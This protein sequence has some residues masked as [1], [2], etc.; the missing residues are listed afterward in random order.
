LVNAFRIIQSPTTHPVEVRATIVDDRGVS[1]E[2]DWSEEGMEAEWEWYF[3][4]FIENP[5][6]DRVRASRAEASIKA[7]GQRLFS[8]LFPPEVLRDRPEVQEQLADGA[9]IVVVGTARFQ[10]LHWE[11]LWNPTES[12]PLCLRSPIV[13]GGTPP[14]VAPIHVARQSVACERLNVLLVSSRPRAPHVVPLSRRLV[15]WPIMSALDP[16]TDPVRLETL[17]SPTLEA[18]MSRLHERER[19]GQVHVLH[20][21]MHGVM[22]ASGRSHPY[23]LFETSTGHEHA[24]YAEA[25]ADVLVRHG[26]SLVVLT[27]CQTAKQPNTDAIASFAARLS[28][29]GVPLVIAMRMTALTSMA[30]L[31]SQHFYGE[32]ARR[33]DPL[34]ALAVARHALMA[35][36]ARRVVQGEE[37]SVADWFVPSAFGH[38]AR[39]PTFAAERSTFMGRAADTLE[40]VRDRTLQ[41]EHFVGRDADLE[42]VE[43]IL[44]GCRVVALRG[45]IGVGK[46]TLLHHLSASWQRTH[47][48]AKTIYV[49][50]DTA[51]A[52]T[53]DTFLDAVTVGLRREGPDGSAARLTVN[54]IWD[55]LVRERCLLVLDSLEN[56]DELELRAVVDGLLA[57]LARIDGATVVACAAR[58]SLPWLSA[59]SDEHTYELKDLDSSSIR[60]F[61]EHR[62]PSTSDLDEMTENLV[63][64]AGGNPAALES[65]TSSPWVIPEHLT[66]PRFEIEQEA[67]LPLLE[68]VVKELSQDQTVT[69]FALLQLGEP[70]PIS[71][72]GQYLDSVNELGGRCSADWPMVLGR[73]HAVGFAGVVDTRAPHVQI[74]PALSRLVRHC[75]QIDAKTRHAVTSAFVAL[76]QRVALRTLV[77]FKLD[78]RPIP[79][80]TIALVVARNSVPIIVRALYVVERLGRSTTLLLC[81]LAQ[82]FLSSGDKN[83]YEPTARRLLRRLSQ[84][85]PECAGHERLLAVLFAAQLKQGAGKL[86]ESTQLFSQFFTM[87]G[88]LSA[89]RTDG[90]LFEGLGHMF[91]DVA[92]GGGANP[93]LAGSSGFASPDTLASLWAIAPLIVRQLNLAGARDEALRLVDAAVAA[94]TKAGGFYELSL[95]YDQRACMAAERG[96][97]TEAMDDAERAVDFAVRAHSKAALLNAWATVANVAAA[98]GD[99]AKAVAG[100]SRVLQ[101]WDDQANAVVKAEA[102]CCLGE[103]AMES[104]ESSAAEDY[105][106]QSLDASGGLDG[107]VRAA[108]AVGLADALARQ[109][110]VES[111]IDGYRRAIGICLSVGDEDLATRCRGELRRLF[112]RP[113][114]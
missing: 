20:L 90:R 55:Q 72:C 112:E 51:S 94:A 56:V 109:A 110:K 21:D 32:L 5:L 50:F 114:A 11:A 40:A 81:A 79:Q 101:E 63:L 71:E 74:H 77:E 69:L 46:T 88:S 108:A 18:L 67:L 64:I 31:F 105:F 95:L 68:G 2:A 107:R 58:S 23:V 104:E 60:E 100:Y 82:T 33:G 48:V 19:L 39:L 93:G 3:E 102:L 80:P 87:L 10:G 27:A 26:V 35:D 70:L 25:L 91:R 34:A 41:P 54:E 38:P 97:M 66:D 89:E 6:V 106:R 7:Y 1:W 65:W 78:A 49:T 8:A 16:R 86:R 24:V 36:P 62:Y 53:L 12:A 73:L 92:D 75:I 29:A 103:Y 85:A 15:A 4:Q 76:A 22:P 37:V 47:R 59:L 44:I 84:S 14:S 30:A 98:A 13:R 57:A 17:Q 61:I 113:V 99:T 52:P 83:G 9:A 43:R 111:A 45:I 42:A 96:E 28:A